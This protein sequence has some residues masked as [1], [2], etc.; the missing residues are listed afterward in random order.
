MYRNPILVRK[1][2]HLTDARY[3]A[4]MGVDWISMIL[5]E[6]PASFMQWHALRDW[7]E[8]PKLIAELTS[9]DEMLLAKTIIDAKPNG[10]LLQDPGPLEIPASMTLFVESEHPDFSRWPPDTCVILHDI[11]GSFTPDPLATLDPSRIFLQMDWTAERLETLLDS[12]Y[13]GGICFTGGSEQATGMRNYD[14]MDQ[15]LDV[16]ATS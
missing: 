13:T 4:A 8:G 5:G 15:W 7:V 6:E 10:L 9:P 11:H 1:I 3:F 2:T 16:L 12:G 14:L